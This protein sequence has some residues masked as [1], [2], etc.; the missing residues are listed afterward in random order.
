V[1][2]ELGRLLGSRGLDHHPYDRFRSARPNEH[3][4][5]SIQASLDLGD[6]G[7]DPGFDIGCIGGDIDE[8]LREATHRRRKVRPRSGSVTVAATSS[9]SSRGKLLTVIRYPVLGLKSL[10]IK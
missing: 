7:R 3:A 5:A 6:L 2:G 4:T 1:I 10:S 8:H 9:R